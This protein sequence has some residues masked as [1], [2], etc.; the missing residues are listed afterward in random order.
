MYFFVR[1]LRYFLEKWESMVATTSLFLVTSIVKAGLGPFFPLILKLSTM[2]FS[3]SAIWK[4]P[5]STGAL[6]SIENL[7]VF[8]FAATLTTVVGAAFTVL[9]L[10]DLA[11]GFLAAT[12]FSFLANLPV[13]SS[14]LSSLVRFLTS[15]F[16]FLT[17]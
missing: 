11:T 3:K 8:G 5:S 7:I 15:L 1:Y 10:A 2:N 6:Q 14:D 12:V 16:S 9:A 4:I 17:S 13:S